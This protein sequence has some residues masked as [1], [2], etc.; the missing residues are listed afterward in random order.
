[1]LKGK[2]T[3]EPGKI[4][5]LNFDYAFENIFGK[6]E[7]VRILEHFLACYLEISIEKIRGKVT[8]LPRD[9][10]LESKKTANKQVDILLELEDKKIN[11]ELNNHSNEGIKDRNIVY[12]CNIHGRSLK[13]GKKSYNEIVP[14][15]QINLNTNRVNEELK[16]IYYLRNNKGKILSEKFRIDYLDM[17]L[18][19][20]ICYTEKE[21]PLS[22]WCLLITSNSEEEFKRVLGEIDMEKEIKEELVDKVKQYSEDNEVVALYS[23]YTKEELERNTLIEDAEKKGLS[24]GMKQ[25]NIEIAK[26]MLKKGM[27]ISDIEEITD[28]SKEEIEELKN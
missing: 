20:K 5:P 23:A 2:E 16:E 19:R 24:R 8:I 18:G 4:I 13:Y 6:Q 17:A 1:M 12:A 27:I 22:K 28:L 15:I 11:I 3:L 21:E 26:K 7:H 9:L 10:N 25:R 14:I